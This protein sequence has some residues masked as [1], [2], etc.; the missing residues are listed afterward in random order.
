MKQLQRFLGL[1]LDFDRIKND[2][3][4]LASLAIE[5]RY[6]PDEL[7]IFDELELGL[8]SFGSKTVVL[9]MVL[10]DGKL[11]RASLGWIPEGGDEDDFAAFTESE[12]SEVME[13]MGPRIESLFE[14]TLK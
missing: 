11:Q 10:E 7:D 3:E 5:K 12:L 1:Q 9:M 2:D 4:L 6:V 14:T 8:G 13:S